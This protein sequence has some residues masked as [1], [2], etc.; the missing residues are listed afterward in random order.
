L[1]VAK[2]LAL[3]IVI[4]GLWSAACSA[5]E[6]AV[7]FTITVDPV[8]VRGPS[9]ALVTVVE[10]SDYECPYCKRSQRV[11]GQI[12]SEYEGRIRLVFKD[13]PLDS[14]PGARPAAEA[15]RCAGTAGRYWEY[16][17]L[18]FIAQPD[19]GRDSLIGYAGRLGLNRDVFAACL[20]GGTNRKAVEQD[21]REGIAVGVRGTPTFLIN[22]RR[23]VGAQPIEAFRE[24]IDEALREARGK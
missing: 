20:D 18:L 9:A 21:L 10:F 24:A 11:L 22:G 6:N 17:D 15:A 12:A 1:S 3:V 23:L 2:A 5:Q 7:T 13:F 8:M 14:H 19:F 16:H 4:L